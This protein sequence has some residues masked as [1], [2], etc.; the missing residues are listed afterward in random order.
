MLEEVKEAKKNRGLIA[1]YK[2]N[3]ISLYIFMIQCGRINELMKILY[4]DMEQYK[5]QT[6]EKNNE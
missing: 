1:G 4:K 5:E 3:R 2:P 6:Q